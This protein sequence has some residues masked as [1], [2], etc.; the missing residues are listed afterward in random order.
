MKIWHISDT[1]TYHG[2]LTVPTDVDMVIF[3][4]DCSNPRDPYANEPEVREFLDWFNALPIKHKVFV[5]GNHDT[6]IEHGF[7]H[8]KEI[9]SSGIV[10]LEN[11]SAE[12]EGIKIWGTPYTPEFGFGWAYNKKRDKMDKMWKSIPEGTD[13]VVS[14]GPPMGV[15][16]LSY[17]RDGELEFC[18]C[19]AMKKNMMRL[20]P[21][22]VLFG[23]IHNCQ[24]IIN[25]GT[26]QLSGYK[27]IYSNGSVVTDGKFGRV[28][29][30]GNILEI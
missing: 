23:H 28:S 24:G 6:S 14:H 9:A 4:G 16:D 26:M 29:S 3:S 19:S 7:I 22:L 15:L 20:E 12:I 2:L 13:I 30:N 1:H 11:T 8:K 17:N 10:Y 18:G 25:A 21:K 5:A 27:T